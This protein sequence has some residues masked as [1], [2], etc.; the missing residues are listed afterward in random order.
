MQRTQVVV[1]DNFHQLVSTGH[2]ESLRVET[3]NSISLL[4]YL[5]RTRR[6]TVIAVAQVNKSVD[7]TKPGEKP[8]DYTTDSFQGMSRRPRPR[9]LS[10]SG[11][12]W[13]DAD[14]IMMLH[15]D[16]AINPD[17]FLRWTY[18]A[19]N[20]AKIDMPYLEGYIWKN[21]LDVGWNTTQGA[22]QLFF[23]LNG[24]RCSLEQVQYEDL[25][26]RKTYTKSSVVTPF[27]DL[28]HPIFDP[29]ETTPRP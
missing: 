5:A 21:K 27:D 19:G 23:K 22:D 8:R 6:M 7:S 3:K 1:I 15:N 11:Q 17:S 10:E 4:K 29:N 2:A 18:L 13:F 28:D 20:G 24:L 14:V 12:I 16:L 26:F 9:D 25:P